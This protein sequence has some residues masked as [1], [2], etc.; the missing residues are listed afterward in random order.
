MA[1]QKWYVVWV[2]KTPGIYTT[3]DEAKENVHGVQGAKYQ[4]FKTEW[5]AEQA[6]KDGPDSFQDLRSRVLPSRVLNS[7]SVDAACSGNPGV[8]E[9]QGIH[10]YGNRGISQED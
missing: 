4:S 9:Y 7:I 6:F 5:A 8:V 3:W 1:K 2:G 10:G